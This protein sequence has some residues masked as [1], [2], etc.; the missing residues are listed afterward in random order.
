MGIIRQELLVRGDKGVKRLSVLF[1]SGLPDLLLEM[2]LQMSFVLL[3]SFL[4]PES[5]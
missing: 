4:F 5:L 1:D 3:R 2:M